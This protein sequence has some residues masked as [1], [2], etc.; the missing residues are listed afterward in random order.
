MFMNEA[1]ILVIRLSAM[2]DII[3]ALPAVASL[4]KS[5]PGKRLAWLVAP[6]WMPLLEGNPYLD[7]LIP[8]R[9]H[10]LRGLKASWTGLRALK[11]GFAIDFQG[12]IQSA[13]AGRAAQPN[14]FYGFD[15]SVARE[16]FASIFYTHR[17]AARGP[18]RVERNLQLAE[19]AGACELT[20]EAW[21]PS[22]RDEGTL[23]LT[24]FVL[25]SPFAGWPSKQWPIQNYE[26]LAE[27]LN[28]E[29]LELVA[30]VPEYRATELFALRHV[31]VHTS[32]VA[33][34]IA[35][36]R[37]STAV[38]GLD[39]GPLHLAAALRKPGVALFGPTDPMRTGPYGGSMIVLRAEDTKT[40]YARHDEIHPSM[41]AIAVEQVADALMRSIASQR[42]VSHS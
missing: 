19:A 23:P 2:G 35:A 29:G 15:S 30:N 18:H 11:P 16:P 40:T 6:K 4:K 9:R 5:F 34:L 32:S 10:G 8:F 33:G 22:G 39:S 20:D 3:H 27:R 17:I 36:T 41:K 38:I 26:P 24:P 12:L 21:L 14:I 1:A 13:L 28:R 25:A 31:R 37:R 7:D 42:V